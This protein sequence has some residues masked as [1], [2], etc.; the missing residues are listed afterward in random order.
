MIALFNRFKIFLQSF[1][2][3]TKII[4]W[5]SSSWSCG[6]SRIFFS[7]GLSGLGVLLHPCITS[8]KAGVIKRGVSRSTFNTITSS[9]L[10]FATLQLEAIHK[11]R[12][13]QA[14]MLSKEMIREGSN[15]SFLITEIASFDSNL[16]IF[17]KRSPENRICDP[18]FNQTNN[19]CVNF[20][21]FLESCQI[22]D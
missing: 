1:C 16:R 19:T 18:F 4:F 12:P 15:W 6:R 3:A 21:H 2:L 10:Y 17:I 13:L 8:N 5:R 11:I 7:G 14:S 22:L 20:F 9:L